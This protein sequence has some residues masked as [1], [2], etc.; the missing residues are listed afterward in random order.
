MKKSFPDW[1]FVSS[2]TLGFDAN[3]VRNNKYIIVNTVVNGH[4]V[5]NKVKSLLTED[6]ILCF[7]NTTNFDRILDDISSLTDN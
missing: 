1:T 5:Y 3:I 7:V 6:N 2:D 4:S